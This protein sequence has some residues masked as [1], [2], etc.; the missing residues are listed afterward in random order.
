MFVY[1]IP[2]V[3]LIII[4]VLSWFIWDKR[5]NHNQGDHVPAG[6]Q[7]TDEVNIDP[8]DHKT[9]RVYYNPRTGER[10]YHAEK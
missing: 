3:I 4:A 1:A 8:N 10:F 5:Y 6:F 9:Y 7:P 2:Y